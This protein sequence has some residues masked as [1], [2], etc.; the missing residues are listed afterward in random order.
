MTPG[1]CFGELTTNANIVIGLLNGLLENPDQ[2]P[3]NLC[4]SHTASRV[5]LN[6][7]DGAGTFSKARFLAYR[8]TH[9]YLCIKLIAALST[10]FM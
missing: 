9:L 5:T 10:L 8:L 7:A 3:S 6:I 1:T 4:I 2:R